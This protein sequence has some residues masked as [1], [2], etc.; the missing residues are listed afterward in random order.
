L[1]QEREKLELYVYI[2]YLYINY[3][4]VYQIAG[5]KNCDLYGS[6]DMVLAVKIGE[7]NGHV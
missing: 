1:Q 5:A 6:P 3:T 2:L 4:Y 7:C